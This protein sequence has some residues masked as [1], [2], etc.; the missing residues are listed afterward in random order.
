MKTRSSV[1]V[2]FRLSPE[3]KERLVE[4]AQANFRS[5]NAEIERRLVESLA[6]ETEKAPNANLG[7]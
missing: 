1:Q 5:L 4:R 3:V 7:G 2:N 6:Q